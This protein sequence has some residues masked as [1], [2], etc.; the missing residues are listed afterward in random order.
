MPPFPDTVSDDM[1]SQRLAGAAVSELFGAL[2]RPQAS[3]AAEPFF[4]ARNVPFQ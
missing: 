4:D 3:L 1:A 2:Q